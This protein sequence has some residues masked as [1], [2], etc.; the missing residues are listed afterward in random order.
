MDA[1]LMTQTENYA[2]MSENILVFKSLPLPPSFM[3][4]KHDYVKGS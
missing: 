2:M 3:I 4:S 1:N